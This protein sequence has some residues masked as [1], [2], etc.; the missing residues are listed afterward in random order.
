MLLPFRAKKTLGQNFLKFPEIAEKIVKAGNVTKDDIVLEIG[1]GFG[2]LTKILAQKAKKVIAIELDPRLE[3]VLKKTFEKTKNVEL[4][5]GDALKFE[6]PKNP[7]KII[8]NI[9]YSITSPLINHFLKEQ[10]MKRD[11]KPPQVAV[12]MIQKEVA[13]KICASPPDMNVLALNIQLFAKPRYLFTIGKGAFQP[14]PKVDSAVIEIIPFQ[15]PLVPDTEKLKQCFALI[16]KAF[17]QKRKKLRNTLGIS[18]NR[19]PEELSI[20][21]WINYSA[22]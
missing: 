5:F 10:C 21:E 17:S 11:G 1:P 3:L 18:D 13:K 4:V 12:L 15:K 2:I 7:Y 9:P 19:R 14:Q 22:A 16:S 20:L 8:A 6:P